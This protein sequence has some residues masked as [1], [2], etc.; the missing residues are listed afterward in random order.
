MLSHCG[1]LCI[2]V[3]PSSCCSLR[4]PNTRLD[5]KP[6]RVLLHTGRFL[7]SLVLPWFGMCTSKLPFPWNESKAQCV[8]K[9]V[10]DQPPKS[11]AA[12]KGFS[13]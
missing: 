1:S 7:Y 13:A 2:S 6:L 3:G 9:E 5:L 10:V 12:S 11:K 4:V 8:R